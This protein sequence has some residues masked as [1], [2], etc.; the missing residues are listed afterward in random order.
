[1]KLVSIIVPYYRKKLFFLKSINSALK[2]TYSNIEIIIIYDDENQE[3]LK[4]FKKKFKNSKKIKF[5]V[6]KLIFF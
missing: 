5:I 4:F 3:D 2:Q 6:N 1:M